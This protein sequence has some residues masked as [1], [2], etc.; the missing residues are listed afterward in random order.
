M[1]SVKTRQ[2]SQN[3]KMSFWSHIKAKSKLCPELF[4]FCLYDI[5]IQSYNWM[6][7]SGSILLYTSF[8]TISPFLKMSF[9]DIRRFFPD[10][11]TFLKEYVMLAAFLVSYTFENVYMLI[12]F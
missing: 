10:R 5:H 12:E 3:A 4:R 11:N 6:M 1:Q 2:M 7:L 8:L 9:C